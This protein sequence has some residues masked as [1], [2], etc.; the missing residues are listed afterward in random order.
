MD[1][2]VRDDKSGNNNHL[3][4]GVLL[5]H[6][7]LLKLDGAGALPKDDLLPC[8]LADAHSHAHRRRNIVFAISL[9]IH[10]CTPREPCTTPN[11]SYHRN[12][13]EVECKH[14]QRTSAKGENKLNA[15]RLLCKIFVY[16]TR[17]MK[18]KSSTHQNQPPDPPS[19][20]TPM[21]PRRTW[22]MCRRRESRC[23]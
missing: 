22:S 16:C 14:V 9:T 7:M 20:N 15:L 6:T 11:S 12:V 8:L 21:K 17:G 1:G 4:L 13:L 3:L 23:Q 18:L 19:P 2:L 5:S 10:L